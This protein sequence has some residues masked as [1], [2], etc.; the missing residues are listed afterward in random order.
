MFVVDDNFLEVEGEGP[1]GPFDLKTAKQ[2]A[3]I[4]A[5]KAK[6]NNRAV[7]RGKT[8]SARSFDLVRLYARGSGV[9]LLGLD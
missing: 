7:T 8:P 1:Y 5:T 9:D 4:A 3:R 2:Y 6:R